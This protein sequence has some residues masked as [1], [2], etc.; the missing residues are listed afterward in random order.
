MLSVGGLLA[1]VVADA[2]LCLLRHKKN[3]TPAMNPRTISGT[4]TPIAAFA[5]LDKPAPPAI[6]VDEACDV[7]EPVACDEPLPLPG[8]A[9]GKVAIDVAGVSREERSLDCQRTWIAYAENA[10]LVQ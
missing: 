8:L 5:P 3:S 2:L 1:V 10:A 6:A 4:T 7:V 9:E